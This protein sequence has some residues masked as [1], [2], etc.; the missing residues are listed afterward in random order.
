MA[1]TDDMECMCQQCGIS[2]DLPSNQIAL[3]DPANTEVRLLS[4]LCVCPDC[5]GRLFLVGKAGDEPSYR[6]K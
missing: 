4:D 1:V 3:E 6:T 2:T 5:A